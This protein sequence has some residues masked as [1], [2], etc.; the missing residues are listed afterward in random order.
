[1]KYRLMIDFETFEHFREFMAHLQGPM[2]NQVSAYVTD[3]LDLEETNKLGVSGYL[4][5][6]L[7]KGARPRKKRTV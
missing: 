7:P 3:K 1:M 5:L 4:F 6:L 2:N